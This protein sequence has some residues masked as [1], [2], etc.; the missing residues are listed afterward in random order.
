MPPV[1][2]ALFT[3]LFQAAAPDKLATPPPMPNRAALVS[4]AE[5]KLPS[6]PQRL[7]QAND[8]LKM[9]VK[10]KLDADAARV[11]AQFNQVKGMTVRACP[12]PRIESLFPLSNV[13]PGGTVLVLGCG[14][15][16]S[17]QNGTPL[18]SSF[19]LT[20]ES[21]HDILLT[22]IQWADGAIGGTLPGLEENQWL[23]GART[24]PAT[25]RVTTPHGTDRSAPVTYRAGRHVVEY[26]FNRLT[27]VLS[28]EGSNNNCTPSDIEIPP[29]WAWC[30]HDLVRWR[31][32]A[33]LSAKDSF[34]ID[35]KNGWTLDSWDFTGG[36]GCCI[37]GDGPRHDGQGQSH[38]TYTMP[39]FL[40]CH[41]G[42]YLFYRVGAFVE[43]EILTTPW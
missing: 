41:N 37:T 42:C 39:W 3:V 10:A 5:A 24:G 2:L 38:W 36:A 17:Q 34:T 7:K 18:P 33:M 22:N 35:L 11:G 9:R 1:H 20:L 29:K 16:P 15:G 6:L 4:A 25:F 28:D 31:W 27:Y 13:T 43:G 23:S 19:F 12:K 8:A 14:F 26:P 32:D 21:G 30:Y 40:P